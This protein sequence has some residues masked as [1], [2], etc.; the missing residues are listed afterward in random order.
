MFAILR[1]SAGA[2]LSFEVGGTKVA[3]PSTADIPEIRQTV[4]P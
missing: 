1:T 3:Y 2:H 4:L